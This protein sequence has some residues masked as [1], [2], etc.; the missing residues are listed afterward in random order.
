LPDRLAGST[1]VEASL[2]VNVVIS[3]MRPW[4][5]SGVFVAGAV[6]GAGILHL[7]QA[8]TTDG[9]IPRASV[10]PSRL[11]SPR[12]AA[13]STPTTRDP[14]SGTITSIT[15][16]GIE[17]D[18]GSDRDVAVGNQLVVDRGG[19]Y[20]ALLEVTGVRSSS[21][22][23]RSLPEYEKRPPQLGDSVTTGLR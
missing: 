3:W 2:E 21:A 6:T 15:R 1:P 23:T 7:V 18:L 9:A 12:E 16:T 5:V 20:V 8:H 22:T 14:V 17:I 10:A 19:A 11:A 13:L 4:V